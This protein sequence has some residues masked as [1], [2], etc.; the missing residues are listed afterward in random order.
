MQSYV[1]GEYKRKSNIL[2]LS[3]VRKSEFKL[4]FIR[5]VLLQGFFF[6]QYLL[7]CLMY[8]PSLQNND[9]VLK[10][11]QTIQQK[12]FVSK[13]AGRLVFVSKYIHIFPSIFK[14]LCFT[15]THHVHCI[16]VVHQSSTKQSG[17]RIQF[18]RALRPPHRSSAELKHY[19]LILCRYPSDVIK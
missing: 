1:T 9:L 11:L 4:N 18:S 16:L 7:M 15:V 14:S 5:F 6:P 10:S 2:C 3:E 17:K 19:L 12:H 13:Y 8:N